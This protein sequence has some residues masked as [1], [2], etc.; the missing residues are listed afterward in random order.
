MLPRIPRVASAEDFR[1]FVAAGRAL[2]DLHVGY[3]SVEPYPLTV[4]GDVPVGPRSGDLYDWFRV[5]KMRFAGT[6]RA[7]DRSSIVYN[8]RI[9]VSGIP[10]EA[11]EYLLGSRSGIEWVMERYR[12]R[13]DRASGIVN[14]PNDWSREVGDPRYVLDLLRRVV[15]VSVET[16]RIVK[17]LPTLDVSLL[18]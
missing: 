14:D 15:T 2:A 16:A 9:T 10:A 5:E 7:K 1:A 4:T 18:T 8:P 6:G 12:V 11:H 17:T 13:T 3:E